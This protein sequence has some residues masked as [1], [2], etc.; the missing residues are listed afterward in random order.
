MREL[1]ETL[2]L[3]PGDSIDRLK[4]YDPSFEIIPSNHA[5]HRPPEGIK[6]IRCILL[7]HLR[8]P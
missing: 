7:L 2:L 3:E 8:E 6:E 1:G 5:A 4:L